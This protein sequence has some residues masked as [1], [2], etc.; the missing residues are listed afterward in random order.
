GLGHWSFD[1]SF[2]ANPR[3]PLPSERCGGPPYPPTWKIAAFAC[4]AAGSAAGFSDTVSFMP[5]DEYLQYTLTWNPGG[6]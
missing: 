2:P 3:P 4:I 1:L 6:V 5:V